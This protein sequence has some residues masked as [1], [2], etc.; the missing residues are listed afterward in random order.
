[1]KNIEH[2]S[3]KMAASDAGQHDDPYGIKKSF[4]IK[5]QV[6][7]VLSYSNDNGRSNV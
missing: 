2:S 6:M 5:S 7:T 3:V 1:M 4:L